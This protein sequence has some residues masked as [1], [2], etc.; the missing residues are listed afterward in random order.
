MSVLVAAAL[1]LATAT[2]NVFSGGFDPIIGLPPSTDAVEVWPRLY[3]R[4]QTPLTTTSNM[5]IGIG[6]QGN[7][8]GDSQTYKIWIRK[9]S[10]KAWGYLPETVPFDADEAV[11]TGTDTPVPGQ[12][13]YAFSRYVSPNSTYT[14]NSPVVRGRNINFV[15]TNLSGSAVWLHCERIGDT[16]AW[17]L[18][19]PVP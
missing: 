17:D 2:S 3:W 13:E 19:V 9:V 10:T 14:V 18:V 5:L 12:Q 15:F 8:T 4:Q 7:W 11:S 6:S 16:R 1:T